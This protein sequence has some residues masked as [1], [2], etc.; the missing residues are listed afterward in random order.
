MSSPTH[1]TTRSYYYTR[2]ALLPP[3]LDVVVGLRQ[4][5]FLAEYWRIVRHEPYQKDAI[6]EDLFPFISSKRFTLQEFVRTPSI[7]FWFTKTMPDFETIKIRQDS[8]K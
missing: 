6:A 1:C 7:W 3:P 4:V 2:W 5:H 8:M